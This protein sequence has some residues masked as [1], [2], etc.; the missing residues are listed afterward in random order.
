M[1]KDFYDLVY[2]AWRSGKDPDAV[3]ADLYEDYRNNGYYP[4]EISLGMVYPK[5]NNRVELTVKSR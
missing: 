5:N 4:D 1:E 2:D 3:S